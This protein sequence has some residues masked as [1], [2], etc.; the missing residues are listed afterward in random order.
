[1]SDY[2]VWKYPI[3]APVEYAIQMPTG[4]E[5]LDVQLQDGAPVLW[6]RVAPAKPLAMRRIVVCGSGD[7]RCPPPDATYIA[8]V[9]EDDGFVWHY[10]DGGEG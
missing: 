3:G 6:A 5:L 1:M 8:T 9:Q 2:V 7:N 10:F 4:A